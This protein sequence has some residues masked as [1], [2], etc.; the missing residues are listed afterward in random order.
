MA[1]RPYKKPDN[2]QVKIQSDIDIKET[3]LINEKDR[4]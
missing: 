2:L 1:V 3:D 4:I